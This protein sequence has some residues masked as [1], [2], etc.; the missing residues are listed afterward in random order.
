M[1]VVYLPCCGF[2]ILPCQSFWFLSC[3]LVRLSSP[4]SSAVLMPCL[5]L[6]VAAV[7]PLSGSTKTGSSISSVQYPAMVPGILLAV[8]YLL[9]DPVVYPAFLLSRSSLPVLSPVS[10]ITTVG[11]GQTVTQPEPNRSIP[12]TRIEQLTDSEDNQT[13][14]INTIDEETAMNQDEKKRVKEGK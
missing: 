10:P 12:L 4:L 11:G 5:F 9:S 2:P 13:K 3:F 7:V 14:Q 6:V 8:S 1:I